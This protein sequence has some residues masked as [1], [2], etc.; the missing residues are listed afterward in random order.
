MATQLIGTAVSQQ[1]SISTTQS[2]INVESITFGVEPEFREQR[3]DITGHIT[4][5]AV[6]DS[7]TNLTISGETVRSGGALQGLLASNFYNDEEVDALVIE[8]G[9]NVVVPMDGPITNF[10]AQSAEVGQS[11]GAFENG[12]V[13]YIARSNL[14]VT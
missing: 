12:S 1:F 9:S 10:V 4:G 2:G 3:M 7:V 11:R 14:I 6:S 13:T 5:E 8:S